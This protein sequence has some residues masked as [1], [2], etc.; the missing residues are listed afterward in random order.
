M[1][2]KRSRH[3]PRWNGR[4]LRPWHAETNRTLHLDL[5]RAALLQIGVQANLRDLLTFRA[6]PR[7]SAFFEPLL[8]LGNPLRVRVVAVSENGVVPAACHR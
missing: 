2:A 5:D 7:A 6:L 8:Q 4:R 1:G 3:L